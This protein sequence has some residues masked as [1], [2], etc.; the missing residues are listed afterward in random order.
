M[1]AGLTGL[2][3]DTKMLQAFLVLPAFIV[4]YLIAGPPR[5]GKRLLQ[6]SAAAAT[7]VLSAGWWVAIVALWPAASRP[8]IG[9]TTNNSII[10][11]ISA[12]TGSPGS[13]GVRAAGHPE[14]QPEA[15]RTSVGWPA[16]GGCSTASW[17]ARFRG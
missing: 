7:L 5:L 10:S 13:S 17:A 3:F 1:A 12:T 14:R 9:S 6:L 16:W 4:V 2:A 11:L 8:Y 15:A